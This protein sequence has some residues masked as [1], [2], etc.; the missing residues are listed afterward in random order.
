MKKKTRRSPARTDVTEESSPDSD[1]TSGLLEGTYYLD[2]TH[3]KKYGNCRKIQRKNKQKKKNNKE[4]NVKVYK[5]TSTFFCHFK[6]DGASR[7]GW[8]RQP[9]SYP[10]SLPA[11]R[12]P[13]KIG[14]SI[15]GKICSN[16]SK[17]LPRRAPV[18]REAK[19]EW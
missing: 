10:I 4:Q 1:V 15:K 12:S 11:K 8:G 14:C 17:F 18:R 3:T 13:S 7:E 6:R 2:V 19:R 5:Y 9:L 16:G